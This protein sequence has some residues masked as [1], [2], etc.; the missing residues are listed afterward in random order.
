MY[1]YVK[2]K[3]TCLLSPTQ[4]R[5]MGNGKVAPRTFN[6][7][8]RCTWVPVS[9]NDS[10]IFKEGTPGIEFT[11]GWVGP[12]PTWTLF[13]RHENFFRAGSRLLTPTC[14]I[15][16]SMQYLSSC[17]INMKILS[18]ISGLCSCKFFFSKKSGFYN[19][20]PRR[21]L[22][23]ERQQVKEKMFSY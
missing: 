2:I 14:W 1:L 20:V 16:S 4:W 6:L 3:S 19:R 12:R 23:P 11:G 7:D 17:V 13:R 15:H 9:R 10:C 22:G 18:K 5:R 8:A 21:T